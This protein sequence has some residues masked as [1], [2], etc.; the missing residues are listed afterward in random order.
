[1]YRRL[2]APLLL[3]FSMS[4][5]AQPTAP[6][7]A[8]PQAGPVPASAPAPRQG[9]DYEVLP[10]PQPTYGQGKIEVA[11]VFSYRCIHCAQFQPYVNNWK[12][13]LPADVRWEYVPGVFGGT[14]D[15][16]ARAY[17]AAEILGVQAKTHDAVFKGVFVD[18]MVTTGTP[19]EI[20]D[21]YGKFGVDRA[22]F[23]A[24]SQSFG[25]TAKLNRAKQFALRTGVNATPTIIVNGKYRVNVTNDRGFDGM[26]STVSYLVARERATTAATAKKP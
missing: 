16:F 19:D 14:W 8:A 23:L 10:T 6:A 25:V 4:A 20:A 22:K 21:M 12:K 24:T 5:C 3:L 15:D 18:K 11:E 17:F 2:L 7:T 13:N 26:L 9:V 1:M